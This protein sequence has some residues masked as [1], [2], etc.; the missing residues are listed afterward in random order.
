VWLTVRQ[1]QWCWPVGMVNVAFYAYVFF[2]AKLYADAVLQVVYFAMA[3]YGWWAWRHGGALHGA[4][5]VGRAPRA[6]LAGLGAAG[7]ALTVSAGTLLDR[8]TDASFPL[9]DAGTTAFSLVAQVLTTRKWI[10]SWAI[11]IVVDAVYVYMYVAKELYATAVLY[12]VFLAMA[13]AGWR[14]WRGVL[15]AP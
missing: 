12:A 7:S 2:H 1:S 14:A 13:V 9:L 11:W 3:V 10:E 15:A 8:F 5:P 6:V 4:L